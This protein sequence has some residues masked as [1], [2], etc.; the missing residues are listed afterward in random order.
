MIKIQSKNSRNLD[1]ICEEHYRGLKK[2]IE[3]K[4]TYKTQMHLINDNVSQ[5]LNDNLKDILKGYP[6]KLITLQHD[7]IINHVETHILHRIFNYKSFQKKA[8]NN[9]YNAYTLAKNLNFNTCPYC[10]RNYTITVVNGRNE[11]I[12]RPDF[13]HFFPQST[14]PLLALSF[15]NLIPCCL[16]CNR[17]LKGDAQMNLQDHLHP[18]LD[19]FGKSLMFNYE[20][21]DAN[22]A[23]GLDTNCTISLMSNPQENP[24]KHLKCIQNAQLF[25]I[26]DIYQES[27]TPE[28]AEIVHKHYI[29]GGAYLQTLAHGFHQIGDMAELYRL[30]FGQ[31]YSEEDH[32]KRPLAKLTRDIFDQLQFLYP[33]LPNPH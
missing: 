4:I 5:F 10:N 23:V 24:D 3:G 14:H 15:Y 22:A 13:D 33:H 7:D 19:G 20:P 11:K 29:S 26:E 30:A 16:I 18:Y 31:Y 28:V 9:K 25:R 1:A 32:E 17:T 21:Q 2:S 6:E 12:I 8:T 27:H